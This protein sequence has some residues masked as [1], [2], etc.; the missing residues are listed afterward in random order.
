MPRRVLWAAWAPFRQ[1]L[2][3]RL[4]PGICQFLMA[5][6]VELFGPPFADPSLP[7]GFYVT[8]S[9][10]YYWTPD[11]WDNFL[12]DIIRLFLAGGVLVYAAARDGA[13]LSSGHYRGLIRD[14]RRMSGRDPSFVVIVAMGNDLITRPSYPFRIWDDYHHLRDVCIS[15]LQ[16]TMDVPRARLGLVFAGSSSSFGYGS[17]GYDDAAATVLDMLPL[18][19]FDFVDDLYDLGVLRTADRL[20]HVDGRDYW[21]VLGFL[22]SRG[23]FLG[24]RRR[25]RAY[26]RDACWFT[27]ALPGGNNT[28][29][30]CSL[31]ICF[32]CMY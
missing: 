22:L 10:S 1:L 16:L 28:G 8:D 11:G 9:F 2:A 32:L 30:A 27:A 17:V 24:P 18:G 4:L 6:A 19:Y 7:V 13:Y 20:G 31:C 14:L 23:F 26:R 25:V 29:A 3:Q 15:L 21:R 12:P 5:P